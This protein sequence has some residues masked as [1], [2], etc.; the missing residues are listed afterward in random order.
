MDYLGQL[1]FRKSYGSY[2]G[3]ICL[4]FGCNFDSYRNNVHNMADCVKCRRVIEGSEFKDKMFNILAE[5]IRTSRFNDPRDGRRINN[6]LIQC[7][8]KSNIKDVL[9][10]NL[11]IAAH[12]RIILAYE[13]CG[14]IYRA[15]LHDSFINFDSDIFER[16]PIVDELCQKITALE[17][18]AMPPS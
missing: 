11:G 18:A 10:C 7:L 1:G 16:L 13:P 14:Y 3:Q 5:H 12:L 6:T 2:Y 8:W 15:N 4:S 9:V 17:K